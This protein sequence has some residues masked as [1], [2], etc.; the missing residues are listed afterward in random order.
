MFTCRE[1]EG[2]GGD[3][4]HEAGHGGIGDAGHGDDGGD[5]DGDDVGGFANVVPRSVTT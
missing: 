5:E 4:S 3:N 2:S 1:W